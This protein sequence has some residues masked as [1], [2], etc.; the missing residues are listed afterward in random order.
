MARPNLIVE[1]LE[2]LSSSLTDI[3][4]AQVEQAKAERQAAF[5]PAFQQALQSQDKGAITQLM[6][7]YP[8]QFETIKQVTGFQNEQKSNALGSLGLQLNNLINTG[9]VQGAAQLIAQNADVLRSAGPGYEPEKLLSRLQQDPNGLAQQADMFSLI[10]LGPQKYYDVTGKRDELATQ[11]QGQAITL[12]GIRSREREGAANRGVQMRGIQSAEVLAAARLAMDQQDFQFRMQQAAQAAQNKIDQGPPLSV[13]MEKELTGSIE[14]ASASSSS[15]DNLSNLANEFRANKP[16]PGAAGKAS[17]MFTSLTGQEDYL[18][19]LRAKYIGLRNSQLVANL[20]PGVASD[21]DIEM[22]LAGFPSEFS[23]PETVA[24]FLDGMAKLERLN[25]QMNGF[26][27]EW[28]SQNG[29]PAKSKQDFEVDGFPVK[30]GETFQQAYKR[31]AAQGKEQ[32]P[33]ES[34][35]SGQPMLPPATGLAPDDEALVNKYLGGQ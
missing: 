3:Q 20:P 25:A 1:G 14:K 6:T 7:Q 12:E 30:K 24:S 19:S 15:A 31:F 17:D 4:K 34:I 18:K 32:A 2:G 16:T 33:K 28:I 10:A 29:N 22:A 13:N 21:K 35:P 8:E 5:L 23:N 26:K 11:Q 27:A 9:N